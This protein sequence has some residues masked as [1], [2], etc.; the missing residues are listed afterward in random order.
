[1]L[2]RSYMK[3]EIPSRSENEAF[4]RVVVAAFVSRLDPTLDE[5]S[6]IKTAV[7]EAVTNAIIH[8]YEDEVGI[9][10]I[11]AHLDGN[12]L[13][14]EINDRG[15]GIADLEQARQPLFTSKPELERSGMGFTIMENFMDEME[16]HSAPGQGTTI[17]LVKEIRSKGD[18][19]EM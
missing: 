10:T 2:Y 12:K 5:I 3:L 9:I 13:F 18:F 4:A 15:V 8:A 17:L 14:V 19:G 1:M 7:S 6:D 16:V 11:N